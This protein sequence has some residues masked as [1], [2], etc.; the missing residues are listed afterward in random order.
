MNEFWHGTGRQ[1]FR[2]GSSVIVRTDCN[3]LPVTLGDREET[4]TDPVVAL[5]VPK[6]SH[7]FLPGRSLLVVACWCQLT[8]TRSGGGRRGWCGV[9]VPAVGEDGSGDG[10]AVRRALSAAGG[11][12]SRDLVCA[13]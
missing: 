8:G 5:W 3:V 13:A 6:S 2:F 12:P 4:L 9:V 10:A 7:P 1:A 11:F